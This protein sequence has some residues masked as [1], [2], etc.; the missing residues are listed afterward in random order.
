MF[1]S[2]VD[3]L[4]CAVFN[5]LTAYRLLNMHYVTADFICYLTCNWHWDLYILF[6]ITLKS[7]SMLFNDR[8]LRRIYQLPFKV[9]F[10]QFVVKYYFHFFDSS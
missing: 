6:V 10:A 1:L 8:I 5:L 9:I 7:Q 4:G 2:L 3:P